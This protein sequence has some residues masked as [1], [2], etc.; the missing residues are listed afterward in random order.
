MLID[1]GTCRG[2][3]E[4]RCGDCIVTVLGTLPKPREALPP[5]SAR[6]QRRGARRF[7][8]PPEAR[9]VRAAGPGLRESDQGNSDQGNLDQGNLDRCDSGRRNADRCDSGRCDPD[10]RGEVDVG[11]LPLDRNEQAVVDLFARA[12]LL[13][14]HDAAQL[15]ARSATWQRHRAVG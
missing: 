13:D 10:E 15:R 3:T 7:P 9:G 1:C 2:Q 4:G 5:A 12:G 11:W 8:R 14:P 6:A